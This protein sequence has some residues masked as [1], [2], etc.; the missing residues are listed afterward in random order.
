MKPSLEVEILS[1][2]WPKSLKIMVV[3]SAESDVVRKE[4]IVDF[5][6]VKF[7][8]ESHKFFLLSSTL[9]TLIKQF[10]ALRFS[11]CSKIKTMLKFIHRRSLS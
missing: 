7:L 3:S 10:L 1:F 11:F 6:A 8:G 5:F 4:R 2:S 9:T